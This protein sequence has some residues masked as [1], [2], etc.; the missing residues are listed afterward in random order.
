MHLQPVFAG[1]RSLLTGAAERLFADG[2]I[3]PSGSAMNESEIGRVL[4]ATSSSWRPL[5]DAGEAMR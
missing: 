3:L 5:R 2:L 4:D 1:A